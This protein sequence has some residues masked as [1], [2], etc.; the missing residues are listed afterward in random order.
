MWTPWLFFGCSRS[1]RGSHEKVLKQII[2]MKAL[3][4]WLTSTH[5]RSR[6]TCP[7]LFLAAS[8]SVSSSKGLQT[9]A[10]LCDLEPSLNQM[11]IVKRSPF[12]HT[13][14]ILCE[15]AHS[16]ERL[17]CYVT[18]LC[19]HNTVCHNPAR[20]RERG[21]VIVKRHFKSEN[22]PVIPQ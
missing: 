14:F 6:P 2:V 4:T 22:T 21:L 13:F 12:V 11:R 3:Q 10:C 18:V 16:Y 19:R 15:S 9:A 5:P 1:R 17:K 8:R 7:P 20:E